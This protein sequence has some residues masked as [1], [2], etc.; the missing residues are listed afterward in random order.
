MGAEGI[1]G[2]GQMQLGGA[3]QLAPVAMRLVMGEFEFR[4]PA[5]D[6]NP[7]HARPSL[8]SLQTRPLSMQQG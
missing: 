2:D 7:L 5:A 1:S 4:Q 8:L 6:P 3:D